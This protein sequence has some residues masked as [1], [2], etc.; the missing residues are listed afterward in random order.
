MVYDFALVKIDLA[1]YLVDSKTLAPVCMTSTFSRRGRNFDLKSWK[2]EYFSDI[3]RS[4]NVLTFGWGNTEVTYSSQN[5][6]KIIRGRSSEL[7]KTLQKLQ[8]RYI[9]QNIYFLREFKKCI[10][11]FSVVSQRECIRIFNEIGIEIS[12]SNFCALSNI[13]DTCPGDSGSGLIR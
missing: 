2:L 11:L 8:M 10:F 9:H 6:K 4:S 12:D 7:A 5:S 3:E 13:G 1:N